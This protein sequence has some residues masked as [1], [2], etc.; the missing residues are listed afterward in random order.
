MIGNSSE[1]IGV[2]P[3]R[4]LL[5]LALLTAS[6]ALVACDEQGEVSAS[7][8]RD[9]VDPLK[10]AQ[11]A[12]NTYRTLRDIA[13]DRTRVRRDRSSRRLGRSG[14]DLLPHRGD[15]AIHE[16]GF[17]TAR[18]MSAHGVLSL[19]LVDDCNDWTL[20]EKWDVEFLDQAKRV[21]R[22]NLLYRASEKPSANRFIFAYS[23]EHLGERSDFIG[24]ALPVDGGYLA[25]FSEPE[26]AALYLPADVVFP[27]TH[28]RQVLAAARRQRDGFQA[29]VFDGGNAIAYR[30][31]TV[32]GRPLRSND[33]NPRIK[34]ARAELDEKTSDRL[35]DGR[36]WPVTVDYFPLDDP[37]APPVFTRSFVL[38]ESGVII[39]HHV[40][41][42]DLQVDARLKNLDILE[43]ADCGR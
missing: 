25:S 26:I 22:S 10:R 11:H 1:T 30:A 34:A 16:S 13:G 14:A 39:S 17:A 4:V 19:S 29:T 42:G 24:D 40:D 43:P 20:Q 8:A 3:A 31:E 28:L 37:Y 12:A 2:R 18:F 27:I 15:Y 6:L 7:T 32:I 41:Y 5:A 9:L 23:Q 38:H 35:P 36:T 33:D 21:H